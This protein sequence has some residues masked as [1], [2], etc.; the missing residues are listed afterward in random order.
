MKVPFNALYGKLLHLLP[1]RGLFGSLLNPCHHL[2]R[3]YSSSKTELVT[4]A[5]LVSY[6]KDVFEANE[7][8]EAQA[9]SEYIVS[10]VLGAKTVKCCV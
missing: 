8:P 2:L 9:S 5:D 4:A 7:I 10:H 3:K 1:H 6:W